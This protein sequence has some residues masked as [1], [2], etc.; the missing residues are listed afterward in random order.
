MPPTGK[1]PDTG[2]WPGR[3]RCRRSAAVARGRKRLLCSLR[4]DRGSAV[5]EFPMVAVLVIVI[6]IAIIQASLI[7]HTRNTLIDAAVQGAHHA[8]LVGSTPESGAER[9]TQL[10]TDRFGDGY[11]VRATAISE[12]G[13][14][15]VQVSAT[16]PLVG[17]LGPGATLQVEGRALEEEQW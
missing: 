3:R 4:S 7:L 1:R 12:E 8:A 2:R 9:T 15:T 11:E 17:M 13:I 6:A 14:V 5:A 16:L 10:I